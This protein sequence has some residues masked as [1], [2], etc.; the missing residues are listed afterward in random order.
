LSQRIDCR[1]VLAAHSWIGHTGSVLRLNFQCSVLALSEVRE[2]LMERG[3]Y[4]SSYG[5]LIWAI[6]RERGR[7]R[8]LGAGTRCSDICQVNLKMED[9]GQGAERHTPREMR[10]DSFSGRQV[11]S[12]RSPI[13]LIVSTTM[14]NLFSY[15]FHSFYLQFNYAYLIII[16]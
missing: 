2:I 14:R 16:N 5:L 6:R 10:V 1:I 9:I 4:R 3:L 7:A 12:V 15:F 13:D 11:D 8:E